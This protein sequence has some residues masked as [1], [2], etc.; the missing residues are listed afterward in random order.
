MTWEKLMAA[1][2][3]DKHLD[4]FMDLKKVLDSTN[5][6]RATISLSNGTGGVPVEVNLNYEDVKKLNEFL[7]E[8]IADLKQRFEEL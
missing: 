4:G 6:Q 5:Y 1:N 2:N 7:D 8:R 3:I